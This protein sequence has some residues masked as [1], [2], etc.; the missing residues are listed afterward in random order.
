MTE[1]EEL[2]Q[3][4]KEYYEKCKAIYKKY[5]HVFTGSNT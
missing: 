1:H 4:A 3:A 2:Q 5:S